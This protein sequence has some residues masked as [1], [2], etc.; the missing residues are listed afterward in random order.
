MPLDSGRKKDPVWLKVDAIEND[1][2]K[3]V[4]RACD[5]VISKKI[6]RV[7]AHMEKCRSSSRSTEDQDVDDELDE[8]ARSTP[9]STGSRPTSRVSESSSPA[10]GLKRVRSGTYITLLL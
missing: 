2:N 6:E 5:Q 9:T 7:K 8:L 10:C 1:K 3:C 4:C